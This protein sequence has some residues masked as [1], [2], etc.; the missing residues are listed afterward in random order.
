M[1]RQALG[2]FGA[3]GASLGHQELHDRRTCVAEVRGDVLRR[4]RRDVQRLPEDSVRMQVSGRVVVTLVATRV[5]VALQA[6]HDLLL[7]QLHLLP[8]DF[9][10]A[11]SLHLAW[12]GVL[13][14]VAVQRTHENTIVP[15]YVGVV[16]KQTVIDNTENRIAGPQVQSL[17]VSIFIYFSR[18]LVPADAVKVHM[19]GGN[20]Q[21]L[22]EQMFAFRPWRLPVRPGPVENVLECRSME[23]S[24]ARVFVGRGRETFPLH[25]GRAPVKI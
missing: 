24:E 4:G 19:W 23:V 7:H 2:H 20:A 21:R 15:E 13:N 14:D 6:W 25:C 3:I 9:R 8:L 5:A 17:L 22:Q 18:S 12:R 10:S 11:V 1:E 16:A